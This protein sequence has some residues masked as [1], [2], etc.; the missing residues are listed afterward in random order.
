MKV[1]INAV[2]WDKNETEYKATSQRKSTDLVF[3]ELKERIRGE[4][5][6]VREGFQTYG[7][8]D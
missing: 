6:E 3:K 1:L 2:G 7:L 8:L 5:E 4:E